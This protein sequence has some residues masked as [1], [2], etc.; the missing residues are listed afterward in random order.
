MQ[1]FLDAQAAL[2]RLPGVTIVAVS[3][4]LPP[5]GPHRESV[6]QRMIVA[7]R[8]RQA[9]A[10]DGAGGTGGMVAWRS[11]TPGYFRALDIP[12]ERGRDFTE[13]DSHSPQ[14]WMIL[15]KLLADRLFPGRY[16]IQNPIGQRVRPSPNEP[17]FT[18]LGVAANVKNAGLMESD[19]PEYYR[20]RR[21]LPEDWGRSSTLLI[22]A[23]GSAQSLDSLAR[24]VRSQIAAVDPTLPVEI[25]TMSQRVDRLADGPRF[26]ALLLSF[27]ALTGLVMAMVGLYGLTAFLATQRTHEIG[28]RMALGADRADVL[29][30]IAWE[31]IRL[32]AIGGLVGLAVALSVSRLLQSL[33]FGVGAHDPATL[34]AVTGLL[35][36]VAL[37]ATLIPARRATRVDPAVALRAE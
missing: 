6:F 21:D 34:C 9:G 5:A 4:S 36:L 15:S 24:W 1:F 29:R 25:G 30:L 33:L 23:S 3:D 14:N 13:G 11:V 27:F 18:V 17:E 37:V 19:E 22:E 35:A 7:G 10:P 31:G 20:L 16:T 28:I 26:Q 32:I 2:R 12:I 8:P